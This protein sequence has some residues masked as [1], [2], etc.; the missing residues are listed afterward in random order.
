MPTYD[1]VLLDQG[2]AFYNVK[3]SA[4]GA[5][6]NGT[7]D[8]RPA[9]QGAIDLNTSAPKTVYLPR[10]TYIVGDQIVV[11]HAVRVIGEG[12]DA[13]IIKAKSTFPTTGK[14]IVRLGPDSSPISGRVE[15]LTISGNAVANIDG[16]YSSAINERG[17]LFNVTITGF[18]RTGLHILGASGGG[19][20]NAQNFLC[21]SLY[22][23]A[24]AAATGAAVGIW[25]ER[26]PS[27]GLIVDS[28]IAVNGGGAQ[29]AAG[30]KISNSVAHLISIRVENY[31][32][33][34]LWED[35]SHGQ[36]L[37]VF[38]HSNV[39]HTRG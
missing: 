7:T 28:T 15:N 32:D 34:I 26:I 30:I 19:S 2:G 37:E 36:A 13:T 16:V 3:S 31:V 38:G 12:P 4:F 23:L 17:G 1:G 20:G 27:R 18:M 25:L 29:Q 8:D 22:V 11:P 24:D 10:G 14:A 9:I 21:E 5:T 39:N 33:G 35:P 6:G